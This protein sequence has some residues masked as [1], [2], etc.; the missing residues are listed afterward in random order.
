LNG[1]AFERL[2][3]VTRRILYICCVWAYA[4]G[5]EENDRREKF[6]GSQRGSVRLPFVSWEK[7]NFSKE[8][9]L[10]S[11]AVGAAPDWSIENNGVGALLLID[12]EGAN[13]LGIKPLLGY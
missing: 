10:F 9:S 8:R 5:P 6:N 3:Y 11:G 1:A 4:S 2:L 12:R 13:V 7:T